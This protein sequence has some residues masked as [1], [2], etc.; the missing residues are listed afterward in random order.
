MKG[1]LE[2]GIQLQRTNYRPTIFSRHPSHSR[3]RRELPLM[4]FR[5][6]IRFGSTTES[7]AR[8]QVNSISGIKNSANK[9]LMKQCFTR[10]GVKTAEWFTYSTHTNRFYK[11]DDSHAGITLISQLQYP[12]ISKSLYGS[13]GNGNVKHDTREQLESWMR[14]KD[15]SNYIFEEYKNYKFEF[16]FHT[17]KNGAFYVCRKALMENT[18][19]DKKWCMNSE[20]CTWYLDTNEKFFRPNS[21]DA[22]VKEC[23]KALH[24][25]QLDFCAFDIRVQGETDGNGRRRAVQDFFIIEGNSAPSLN[26]IGIEHYKTQIPIILRDKYNNI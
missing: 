2:K 7:I 3:L 4:P 19:E 13:R 17:N 8:V 25:L 15:L 9:L 11:N 1:G 18:P 23:I 24:S 10:A 12:I 22:I 26:E 14:G 5:S 6:C 16:R 20:T 21:Y